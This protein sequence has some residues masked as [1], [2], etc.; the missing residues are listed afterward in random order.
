[1]ANVNKAILVGHVGKDPDVKTFQGGGKIAAF[2]LATSEKYTNR[3]GEQIENT[4]W[5][6]IVLNGNL[7]ELA[8]KYVRKGDQLY[9]EGKIRTRS[10]KAQDG[11]TRYTTEI[12]GYSIQFFASGRQ[13]EPVPTQPTAVARTTA[14]NAM[15]MPEPE[16][17]DLPFD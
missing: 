6:N 15:P 3:N 16:V 13:Q 10:W 5:H 11:S 17:E 7:A 1:M 9:V 14:K 8:E 4:E 12:A 2:S